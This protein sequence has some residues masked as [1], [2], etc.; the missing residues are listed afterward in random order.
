MHT[1]LLWS[2]NQW[3][4]VGVKPQNI[5]ATRILVF[6]FEFFMGA[7][8]LVRYIKKGCKCSTRSPLSYILLTRT[9]VGSS[10]LSVILESASSYLK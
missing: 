9:N 7:R 1:R 10:I 5:V 8:F 2:T 6:D 4:L 3:A